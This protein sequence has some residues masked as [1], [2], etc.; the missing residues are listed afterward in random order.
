MPASVGL[1]RGAILVKTS[2]IKGLLATGLISLLSLG[3]VWAQSYSDFYIQI[4]DAKSALQAGQG[5]QAVAELEALSGQFAGLAES[6]SAAGKAV[7]AELTNILADQQVTDEELTI[8]S[9]KL[10]AFEE[11]QNPLDLEAELAKFTNKVFP[12]LERLRAT[13]E[14]TDDREELRTAFLTFNRVWTRNEALVRPTLGH[15]GRIETAL[16]FLRASLEAEPLDK[17]L[18]FSQLDELERSLQ[19]FVAGEDLT[20]SSA[21]TSLKE[22]VAV[23]KTAHQAFEAGQTSQGQAAMRDFIAAWPAFESAVST[24][25]ASLYRYV[26]AQ[27]PLIMVKGA[28]A[29]YQASLADLISQLEAIDVSRAYTIWDSMLILLRE[30]VEALVIVLSLI[31]ILRAT[32]QKRGLVWVNGGAALGVV[33]SGAAAVI[34][35]QFF[36]VLTSGTKREVMEGLVGLL[37]VA[38]MLGIGIW[39]HRK[40]KAQAWQAYLEK[41]MAAVLSTGSFLSMFA[42]A[43]LAVFREGAETIIFYVGI[44]PHIS[45]Q[46]FWAGIGLALLVLVVLAWLFIK[47]SDRLPIHRVFQVLGWL[48]YGLAFKML[49]VSIHTLQLTNTISSHHIP[50]LPSLDWAGFYPSVEVVLPQLL[51]VT[52][53][54][55]VWFWSGRS[56]HG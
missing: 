18:V 56:E 46:D 28:E 17:A 4:S 22:G 40:S 41:R 32:G 3:Q 43:F 12:A 51:F 33:A 45:W 52:V 24:R 30:G 21:I 11:E 31:G 10:L 9:K 2:L 23:L 53:I 34:L 42:L 8:L 47:F 49:G 26:E 5:D 38:M 25:N 29:S 27:T 13:I 15:Y 19:S 44:L 37:A 39:L 55:L 1:E 48:I 20:T 7:T 35:H 36:P 54:G 14:Q 50:W 6:Q 16:S